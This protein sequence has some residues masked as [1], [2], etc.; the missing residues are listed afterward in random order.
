M[1]FFVNSV[2]IDDDDEIVDFEKNYENET[3]YFSKLLDTVL[4]Q[5]ISFVAWSHR[6]SDQLT[7]YMELYIIYIVNY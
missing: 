4:H 5:G 2:K 1:F 6:L 7:T 3:F